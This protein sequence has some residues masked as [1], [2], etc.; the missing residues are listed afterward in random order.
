[1]CGSEYIEYNVG[2]KQY[3]EGYASPRKAGETVVITSAHYTIE[4]EHSEEVVKSGNCEIDGNEFRTLLS[5][6]KVGNYIF[7]VTLHIGE[8]E[9]VEKAYIHVTK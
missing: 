4:E 8:E 6:E 3:L 9:P 2:E 7:R 1:M 5:F